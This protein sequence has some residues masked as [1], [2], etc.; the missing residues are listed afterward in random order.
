M[1]Q[2]TARLLFLFFIPLS[3]HA[4][5]GEGTRQLRP[6]Y[7]DNG[8]LYIEPAPGG[9]TDF[10]YLDNLDPDDHLN[11]HIEDAGEVI[12]FGFGR[13]RLIGSGLAYDTPVP[14]NVVVDYDPL[15]LVDIGNTDIETAEL[16][17]SRES[18]D[19]ITDGFYEDISLDDFYYVWYSLKDPAG[20]S[21]MEGVV[22]ASGNQPGYIGNESAEAYDRA[23]AGP[24]QLVGTTGYWAL[25]HET[26]QSGD[27]R[28]EL[29][30]ATLQDATSALPAGSVVLQPSIVT[31]GGVTYDLVASPGDVNNPG[32]DN[33]ILIG[34]DYPP[35]TVQLVNLTVAAETGRYQ[36]SGSRRDTFVDL[37]DTDGDGDDEGDFF[38]A[39]NDGQ[40]QP[41][42]VTDLGTG[43]ITALNTTE[44]RVFSRRWGFTVGSFA[45]TFEANLY[46]YSND[47]VVTEIDFNGIQP[48]VFDVATNSF[49]TSNTGDPAV[50][51]QSVTGQSTAAEFRV[52]LQNPD[53][54]AYPSGEVGCIDEIQVN[55]CVDNGGNLVDCVDITTRGNGT[56]SA[57]F[58]FEDFGTVNQLD[59]D[60]DEISRNI[61]VSGNATPQTTCIAFDRQTGTGTTVP[62]GARTDVE[63]TFQAGLTNLPIFDVEDHQNGYL[64]SLVRPTTT[65]CGTPLDEFFIRW[66]DSNL[67]ATA[68]TELT[69]C[70]DPTGCHTWGDGTSTDDP[71]IG[72]GNNNTINT[73]WFVTE[74]VNLEFYNSIGCLLPVE[75]ISFEGEETK[76]EKHR[77]HW[78]TASERNTAVFELEH[79]TDG[80]SYQKIA[81]LK[82]ENSIEGARYNYTYLFPVH[83]ENY[84]RLRIVD[85]D[86]TYEYS[87][88]IALRGPAKE[89]QL[90]NLYPNPVSERLTVSFFTPAHQAFRYRITDVLGR[91]YQEGALR[92][93][94]GLNEITL[95]TQM[96]AKGMY[97][98]YVRDTRGGKSWVK[99]FTHK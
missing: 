34:Y 98:L 12:Y 97:L 30:A 72:I 51:R 28:I 99:K 19:G 11:I 87:K 70:T 89:A 31:S 61:S 85:Y 8:F 66:D 37:N 32:P 91:T 57:L 42:D 14:H 41:A 16:F 45:N 90:L 79:S 64:V 38:S 10:A 60:P 83:G 69:G 55:Q 6:D 54:T 4:Q 52:F 81:T 15:N 84:Y 63:I 44:G 25:E 5:Q 7:D 39:N 53:V 71:P 50:D 29:T 78:E 58:E 9:F 59:D 68:T 18:F 48:F 67:S 95:N 40:V 94:G 77:L 49:G 20:N 56:I 21:V 26:T 62:E 24:A 13:I 1:L 23:V 46:P 74:D 80:F 3:I 2:F 92:A 22:P 33:P 88:V 82:A 36:I 93:D 75:L 35:L 17:L 65:I 96:L 27:Y 47:G 73:Y 76:E 43:A 86:S